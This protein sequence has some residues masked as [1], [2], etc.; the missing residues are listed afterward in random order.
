MQIRRKR[1]IRELLSY[2]SQNYK[3][4]ILKLPSARCTL[5]G[6]G[7]KRKPTTTA[8]YRHFV[9][10]ECVKLLISPRKRRGSV[11]VS[12][13]PKSVKAHFHHS[14]SPKVL[15][16]GSRNYHAKLAIVLTTFSGG[17]STCH[18]SGVES[19]RKVFIYALSEPFLDR[20]ACS[21]QKHQEASA[22][23]MRVDENQKQGRSAGEMSFR[24]YSRLSARALYKQKVESGVMVPIDGG[25]ETEDKE[26][27]CGL[28][29]PRR[30]TE[31][32]ITYSCNH[33][34]SLGQGAYLLLPHLSGRSHPPRREERR[35]RS[36][37]YPATDSG[38]LCP[39]QY[40]SFIFPE[41][42]GELAFRLLERKIPR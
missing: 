3:T 15:N 38:P 21:R 41:G 7:E 35:L 25:C 10:E 18:H 11:W 20:C 26:H 22:M 28:T 9:H 12:H 39:R 37:G 42:P 16:D 6:T 4:L 23:T 27:W 14:T 17:T 34:P 13:T 29:R 19:A 32:P 5:F 30:G 33:L 36:R 24:K 1:D 31:M 8:R 2:V 40:F